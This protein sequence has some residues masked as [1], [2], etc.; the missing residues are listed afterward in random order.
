MKVPVMSGNED[1]MSDTD[2]SGL[3]QEERKTVL[4]GKG[5]TNEKRGVR[6]VETI[7]TIKVIVNVK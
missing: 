7:S 3:K 5:D 2:E 4:N 1:M 6:I